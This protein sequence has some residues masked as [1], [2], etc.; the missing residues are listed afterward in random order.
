R[1]GPGSRGADTGRGCEVLEQD[2]RGRGEKHVPYSMAFVRVR[3]HRSRPLALLA[4]WP[5]TEVLERIRQ[6]SYFGLQGLCP[7]TPTRGMPPR[8]PEPFVWIFLRG[9]RPR[10]PQHTQGSRGRNWKQRSE[11]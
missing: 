11:G 7:R 10:D 2:P 3:S 6:T 5:T 8:L 4:S 1:H 9:G